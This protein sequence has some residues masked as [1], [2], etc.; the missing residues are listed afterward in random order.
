MTTDANPTPDPSDT[1]PTEA[2]STTEQPTTE[3]PTAQQPTVS[4]PTRP[5]PAEPWLTPPPPSAWSPA[6]STAS[7]PPIRWGGVVWGLLLVLFAA[8]TLF[9]LSAPERLAAVEV[10]LAALTPG[11]A[12]A[13]WLAAAGVLIVVFALLGAIRSAQRR[14][15]TA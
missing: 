3:Q 6:T 9:V 1:Q 8:G 11:T 13:L 14:R 7:R 15:Q 10:W 2:L 12:W 5:L 4:Q